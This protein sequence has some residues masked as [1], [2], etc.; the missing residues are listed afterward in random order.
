MRIA[1]RK[2]GQLAG[3]LGRGI[4]GAWERLWFQPF[5]PLPAGVLRI[6]LGVLSVVMYLLLTPNFARYFGADGVL[7]MTDPAL[8]PLVEDTWSAFAWFPGAPVM[9]FWA[10]GLLSAVTFTIGWKTRLSTVVLFVMQMSMVHRNRYAIN[11]EDLVLRMMLLYACFAPMGQTLSLDRWL[12]DRTLG[13][14]EAAERWPSIWPLR[15]MQINVALVYAISLPNKLVDDVA[16]SNGQAIYYSIVSNMW[17]RFPW[18]SL[19]YGATS[20]V[21]TTFTVIVEGLFPILVWF[22]RTRLIAIAA[23]SSLHIGIAFMLKNVT[24]FS[25]GMVLCF[26]AF[27]P[28]DTMRDLWA[29]RGWLAA[30]LRRSQGAPDRMAVPDL[31]QNR[32][33]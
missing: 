29:R 7:S 12:R 8:P 16:W 11:G 17:G 5:D 14:A 2:A 26:S 9:L 20:D 31:T 6:G 13:T 25:L 19:F 27:I 23:L 28:A 32:A 10:V 18:P 22:R 1:G 30:R 24:L 21:M 33:G 3:S 4:A 15:L